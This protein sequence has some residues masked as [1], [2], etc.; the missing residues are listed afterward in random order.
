MKRFMKLFTTT[1]TYY[2]TWAGAV[3]YRVI[4]VDSVEVTPVTEGSIT[5][6]RMNIGNFVKNSSGDIYIYLYGGDTGNYR[7]DVD[8]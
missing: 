5:T 1:N 4:A 8:G 7:V 3:A 2:P 6:E